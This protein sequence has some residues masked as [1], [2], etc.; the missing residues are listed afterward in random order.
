M[1]RGGRHLVV[2]VA[3]LLTSLAGSG[4]AQ[5]MSGCSARVVA[6][7][8]SNGRIDH[9]YPVRCYQEALASLP[10]DLRIYSSAQSDITRALQNRVRAE[11]APKAAS[12]GGGGSHLSP[13]LVALISLGLALG[14]A[15][16]AAITR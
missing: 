15:S 1:P 12:T 14:A 8:R 7:W 4:S 16:V 9:T 10:E 6:D 11:A 2:L 3:V 13:Y 5:A